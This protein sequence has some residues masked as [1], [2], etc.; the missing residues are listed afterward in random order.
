[1]ASSTSIE[2]TKRVKNILVENTKG[3]VKKTVYKTLANTAVAILGGG[4]VSAI[5]GKPSFILGLVVTGAGYYKDVPY[6]APLGIGMMAT[7][8]LS[9]NENTST[10]TGVSGFSIKEETAN[11]KNRLVSFKD[12]LLSKTYIDKVIK[13]KAKSSTSANR[14]TETTTEETTNGFGSVQDNLNVLDNIEQQLVASAMAIQSQRKEQ[15]T[16]GVGDEIF[17]VDEQDFSRF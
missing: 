16:Q 4:L 14:S 15:T 1:M 3:E 13:P 11:A 8:H 17:G 9:S 5:I 10:N 2:T 12:S 7:S 6:L